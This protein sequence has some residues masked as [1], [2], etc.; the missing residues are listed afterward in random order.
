MTNSNL[1]DCSTGRSAG[2]ALLR[3]PGIDADLTKHF[4]EVG[5]VAHQAAGCHKF[6]DRISRRNPVARR[7]GGKLHAA[8]EEECVAGDKEGIGTLAR[9]GGKTHIDLADRTGLEDLD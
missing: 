8:V 4:C 3:M 9:K 2:L 1:V 5:S 6:T 7:Q